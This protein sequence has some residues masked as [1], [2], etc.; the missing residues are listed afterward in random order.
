M[1]RLKEICQLPSKIAIIDI[2]R[3]KRLSKII[4]L[5]SNG[6][7][8]KEIAQA[9]HEDQSTVSRDLRYIKLETRIKYS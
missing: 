1:S 4:S 8:Q 9:L 3:E 6:L 7:N 2:E 5:Y